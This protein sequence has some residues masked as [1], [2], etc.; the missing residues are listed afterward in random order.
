MKAGLVPAFLCDVMWNQIELIT[1]RN[2]PL[3]KQLIAA[4]D[5]RSA[6]KNGLLLAEGLRQTATALEGFTCEAVLFA[7]NEK[8][9]ACFR[10]LEAAG[11]LP[12]TKLRRIE[13]KLFKLLSET[14]QSQGVTAAFQRPAIAACPEQLGDCGRY[15]I[16]E[17]I[18]DP[19]NLGTMIRTAEAFGFNGLIFI[20][21]HVSPYNGK[22]LRAA[23]GSA[24]FLPFY[25]AGSIAALKKALHGIPLYTA[26]MTGEPLS[27]YMRKKHT[28]TGFALLLGNEARG[29]SEEA[30]NLCDICLS[31]PM[32]GHAESLNIASACSVLA[33]NLSHLHG[34]L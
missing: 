23:M 15:L 4:R 16:L 19:G 24:L 21:P 30:L 28:G 8:G 17:E 18:Q 13:A 29:V 10:E 34:F 32:S 27:D 2:N 6:K 22:T 31:V 33:W 5:E 12:E 1:S 26:D 14:E 20:G 25:E 3:L 9:E 7:D 11:I